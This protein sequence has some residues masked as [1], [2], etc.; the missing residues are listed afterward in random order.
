MLRHEF[1]Q[2]LGGRPAPRDTLAQIGL[3]TRCN[4]FRVG[5]AQIAALA[6]VELTHRSH[7][8]ALDRPPLCELYALIE[9]KRRVVPGKSFLGDGRDAGGCRRAA[10]SYPLGAEQTSHEAVQPCALRLGERR[11]VR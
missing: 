9:S 8:S 11:I 10:S 3:R 1:L 2:L 5:L 6:A 4:R 7:H